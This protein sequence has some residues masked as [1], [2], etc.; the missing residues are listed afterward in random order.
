MALRNDNTRVRFGSRGRLG[1]TVAPASPNRPVPNSSNSEATQ[2]PS[3]AAYARNQ[4][5]SEFIL[6]PE[7]VLQSAG[8]ENLSPEISV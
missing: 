3:Q 6:E 8:S 1:R 7:W 2:E 5:P 4:F